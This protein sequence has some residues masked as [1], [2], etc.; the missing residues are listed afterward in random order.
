MG[1]PLLEVGRHQRDHPHADRDRDD[2]QVVAVLREVDA[3]QDAD[4]GCRDHAE[5]HQ[6]CTAQHHGRHRFHQRAHLRHQAQH[7]EDDAACDADKAA[8]DAGHAHQTDVLR[9]RG[10]GEG[11]EDA[12]DQRAQAIGAQAGRQHRLVNL[13]AG[14]VAQGQEHAGGFDHHHDHHQRHGDDHHQVKGRHPEV[15]GRDQAE[16]FG[17]GH[18]G[19]AHLAQGNRN[20]RADHDAQQH[21]DIGDKTLAEAGDQQDRY[22]HDGRDGDVAKRRVLLVDDR[23]PRNNARRHFRSA[24]NC[25]GCNAFVYGLEPVDVRLVHYH[26]RGGAHRV[27]E[28]PVDADPHQGNADHQDDRP[29]HHGRKEPQHPADEG[30]DDDRDHPRG[31][32]GAKDGA[33]AFMAAL[34]IGHGHHRA[35]GGEGD[36]HHHRQLDAEPLCRAK[37]LDQRDDPADEKVGRDQEGDIDRLKL[38]RAADDQGHGDG[39]GIH[40][41][42]VLQAQ[43]E[44]LGRWQHFVHGVD[45][46]THDCVFPFPEGVLSS[47]RLRTA[48]GVRSG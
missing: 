11:V 43:R 36:A 45:L 24:G 10:I 17:L 31:D 19:K 46:G 42:D 30:R 40:D 12:A 27:A 14:H 20:D 48:P 26:G 37:A 3:R 32:N 1:H 7:D 13:L 15:E 47:R 28:D 34:G 38:E 21:R 8:L 9:E 39:A 18:L 23:C 22:Q 41:K 16:P 4:A 44:Q 2:E 33:G 29:G 6:P 25:A 35:D 5:H